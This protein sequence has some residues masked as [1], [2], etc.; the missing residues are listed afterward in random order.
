MSEGVSE[1]VKVGKVL[2]VDDVRKVAH[3]AYPY[4][5]PAMEPYSE[6][7]AYDMLS[8]AV[9]MHLHGSPTGWM[10]Y[11][12]SML[13]TSKEASLAGMKALCFKDHYYM[14]SPIA[15]IIQ[16]SLET[17]AIEKGIKPTNVYGGV[18]LNY[19]VGGLNPHAVRTMLKGD[20]AEYSKVLWM[21]SIDS[22]LTRRSAGLGDGI[23]IL[24]KDGRLKQ[25]VKEI[26]EIV[27]S[28]E[29]HVAVE[30]CHL[31]VE[32]IMKL[33]EEAEKHGVTLVVTH[34][35][36]ELTLL[37]VEEARQLIDMHAW[38]QLVAVSMLGTPIAAPG[39]M[40]NYYHTM[41]LIKKLGPDKIILASDAGQTGAKPVEY[42]KLM[43]WSLL[44]R[45]V[46]KAAIRKMTV[47]NPEAALKL[48]S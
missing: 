20:F 28:A 46:S 4:M 21:P 35:N 25:E 16:E 37:T 23:T 13:E 17:W 43:I 9:D 48:R 30:S 5:L 42:Y 29:Q 27:S 45:G 24:D 26:L 44:T 32:E 34:A 39:W 6:K 12:P 36:Q 15:R 18:T 10:P 33:A 2:T 1:Q 31:Y 14:T 8:G 47:E 3:P 19:A 40:V 38:I 7:D 22:D 11:R 41:E